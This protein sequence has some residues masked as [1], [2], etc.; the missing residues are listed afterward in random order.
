M[1]PILY[2]VWKH[3]LARTYFA[4]RQMQGIVSEGVQ[5]ESS[6]WRWAVWW[7]AGDDMGGVE[8]EAE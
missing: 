4:E 2:S 8:P 5:G 7:T 1:W 3:G 6:F